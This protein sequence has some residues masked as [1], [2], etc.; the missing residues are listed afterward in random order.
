M[1]EE[2]LDDFAVDEA[3]VDGKN[4]NHLD[5][6][7]GGIGGSGGRGRGGIIVAEEGGGRGGGN[8]RGKGVAVAMAMA[9][10]M[11]MATAGTRRTAMEVPRRRHG[12][13]GRV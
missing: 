11:A 13:E 6:S 5:G 2:L 7:R 8:A 9:M 4:M 10:A 1:F 3:I 12:Q